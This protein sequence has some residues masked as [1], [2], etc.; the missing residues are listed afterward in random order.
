M[1]CPGFPHELAIMDRLGFIEAPLCLHIF[2]QS[3]AKDKL[4]AM[5]CVEGAVELCQEM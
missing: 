2:V 5:N 4:I 3:D 1:M